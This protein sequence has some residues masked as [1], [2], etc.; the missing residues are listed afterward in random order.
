MKSSIKSR[1]AELDITRTAEQSVK[2]IAS[3]LISSR[4]YSNENG[5]L[6]IKRVYVEILVYQYLLFTKQ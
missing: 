1:C 6:Q 5:R 3:I 2:K 4:L